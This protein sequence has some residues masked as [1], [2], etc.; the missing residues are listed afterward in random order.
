MAHIKERPT[1]RGTRYDV[2]WGTRSYT[3]KTLEEALLARIAVERGDEPA[4]VLPDSTTLAEFWDAWEARW[5]LGK[6]AKTIRAC[7]SARESLTDLMPYR[8]SQLRAATV[9][10]HIATL[11][12]TAPRQAQLSLAHLKRCLRSAQ[13]R[14]HKID[15]RILTLKPTSYEA[16]QIRF[17]TWAEVENLQAF[18]DERLNRIVPIAALTGMRKGELYDLTDTRVDLTE[19]SV[20]LRKTKTGKP[21]KV[22]LSATARR[23]FREQLVAR[24]PNSRGLVFP[25]RT[26]NRLDSRFERG[27]REAVKHA[28]LDGATF[29]SLRH[30]CASLMIRAGCN[31]LEIAEQLGH[32][33][34]GKPD[35]TMIWQRYG[36]LYDGATRDAVGRLDSLIR[37]PDVKEETA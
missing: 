9:E 36:W 28:G 24:T 4:R 22:W 16:K 18:V 35:A 23:L 19:G 2:C 14:D 7:V 21:R 3:A 26:G 10:D 27:Y 11:A 29:H 33:R 37:E 32:M 17:L 13:A 20:T 12:Q 1:S 30:T 8:L 5:R 25:T 6:S 34:G 31:P 15:L